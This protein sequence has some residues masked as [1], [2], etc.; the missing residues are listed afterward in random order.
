MNYY[1]Q[2]YNLAP[3]DEII[4]PKSNFN[5][6]QHHALYLG[7]DENKTDWII[8]N[9][10]GFGVSLITADEFFKIC[11]HINEIRR[12]IGTN[13]ERKL[14]VQRALMK[15]G[16]PYDFISYNCE[17]FISDVK[18]GKPV[19]K[20]VEGALIVILLLIFIGSFISNK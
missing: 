13:Q 8:H 20:Q 12:F 11:P 18:T 15:I 7:F 17:H 14:L 3:G 9:T 5:I 19:S 16:K 6:I 1:I 10:A 4:V 2:Y